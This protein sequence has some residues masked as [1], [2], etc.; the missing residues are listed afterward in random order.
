MGDGEGG[1]GGQT[2]VQTGLV[3][4]K[5]E[6]L[7]STCKYDKQEVTAVVHDTFGPRSKGKGLGL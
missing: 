6:K 4:A 5:I 2:D 3:L 1:G 7:P